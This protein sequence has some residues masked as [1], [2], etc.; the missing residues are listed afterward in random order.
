[1][2]LRNTTK[3][4]SLPVDRFTLNCHLN[5]TRFTQADFEK[6]GAFIKAIK[7]SDGSWTVSEASLK[8][9]HPLKPGEWHFT[10]SGTRKR[11]RAVNEED[12]SVQECDMKNLTSSITPPAKRRG[13]WS[14]VV[15]SPSK[16][17]TSVAHLPISHPAKLIPSPKPA[18]PH[19]FLSSLRSFF[20]LLSPPLE[21][22]A[23]QLISQ[24]GL[25]S[26]NAIVSLLSL[27]EEGLEYW[28]TSLG[29]KKLEEM[30]LKAAL[31]KVKVSVESS[32]GAQ[33]T[34]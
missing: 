7:R 2:Y 4:S 1:M 16:P 34:S 29:V 17:S 28:V 11:S 5:H 21:R 26:V 14:V 10:A 27:S 19:P 32:C 18:L 20:Y 12:D 30:Q 8:H 31:R 15:P 6:C 23:L 33:K 3:T 13:T 24:G 25:D 22:L 9:S